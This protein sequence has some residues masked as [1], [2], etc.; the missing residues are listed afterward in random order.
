M[1]TKAVGSGNV[2]KYR[3]LDKI[4]H[5]NIHIFENDII[6]FSY[7]EIFSSKMF[8]VLLKLNILGTLY[9]VTT[10]LF[11]FNFVINLIIYF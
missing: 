9:V 4:M 3:N 6:K 10:A 8:L 5:F 11:K 7:I 1:H 2:S